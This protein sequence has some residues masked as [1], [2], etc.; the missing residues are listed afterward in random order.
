MTSRL[1]SPPIRFPIIHQVLT[2]P[3][4]QPDDVGPGPGLPGDAQ[5]RLAPAGGAGNA[6]Q[7]LPPGHGEEPA[8]VEAFKGAG[9]GSL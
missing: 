2:P 1:P 8:P 3:G 7:H 6:G 5:R 9:D 4:S